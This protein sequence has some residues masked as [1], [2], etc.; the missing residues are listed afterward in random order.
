M[1]GKVLVIGTCDTKYQEL[2]FVKKLIDQA[3]LETEMVDVSTGPH[4]YPVDV[5][6]EEILQHATEA[7]STAEQRDRG[8]AITQMAGALEFYLLQ[9][10]N[11]DGVIGLGGSG[12]TALITRGLRALPIGLPKVMIS[13]VASGNVAPYVDVSD[14]TMVNPVTD[15]AGLNRISKA[16][17]SNAAHALAGMVRHRLP[18]DPGAKELVGMTMFGV[19]T[20]CVTQIREM[21][22]SKYESI[23]FHAT[24]TGGRAMG[25]LIA[26]G[27][28]RAV[29]DITTTEICDLH[30][31]GI[32]SAGE[33][34]MDAIIHSRIPYILSV[35][36]M[37][38]V[39]F[40]AHDTVP[41]HYQDHQLYVH[42]P[43]VTLMRTTPEENEKMALWIAHKI[44]KAEGPVRLFLPLKGVSALSIKG[45]AFHWPKADNALF[46]TLRSE[47][48]Q[49]DHIKIIELDCDINAPEFASAVMQEF[50]QLYPA[51]NI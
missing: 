45:A 18:S 6:R 12:G 1:N 50:N 41:I 22:A 43:Q 7:L 49:K 24:G 21:L 10:K 36:A 34:R 26:S 23:V 3:G 4:T 8:K 35:G 17:L 46:N 51:T 30:M 15:I 44:H 16:I 11:I 32:M 37:D 19:T 14:I 29:V 28:I 42:N 48:E 2:E 33:Q 5:T 39:N 20:P 47:I 13:T 31:G 40:G 9:R 27:L 25:K 38:M